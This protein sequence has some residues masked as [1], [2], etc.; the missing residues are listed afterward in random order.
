MKELMHLK[1]LKDVHDMGKHIRQEDLRIIDIVDFVI[2]YVDPKISSCGTWEELFWA[3]RMKKP[4][5]AIIEGGIEYAP[6]W[7]VWTL[8]YN[9]FYDSV[10]SVLQ[11][12]KLIDS[13]SIPI[14]ND[15]WK[16][17]KTK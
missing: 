8:P 3:N 13:G 6:Y 11:M 9:Y 12:L 2:A 15:R 10:D 5:F 7:L 17:L 1:R 14:D 16:L 4:I